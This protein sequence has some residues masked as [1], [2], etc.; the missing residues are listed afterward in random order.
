MWKKIESLDSVVGI[1]SGDIMSQIPGNSF[2]EF[3]VLDIDSGYA[4][5]IGRH[6]KDEIKIFPAVGFCYD[7]WWIRK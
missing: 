1:T 7:E 5:I 3:K 4:C 2:S 6:L